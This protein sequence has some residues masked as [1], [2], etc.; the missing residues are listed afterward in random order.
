LWKGYSTCAV[1]RRAKG[2][3]RIKG[4]RKN[5]RMAS[6]ASWKKEAKE[7]GKIVCVEKKKGKGLP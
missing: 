1:Q 6:P 2:R 7:R 5:L 3:D 4:H